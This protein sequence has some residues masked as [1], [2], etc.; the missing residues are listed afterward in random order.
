MS[1]PLP[2]R[3]RF[4]SCANFSCLYLWTPQK[5]DMIARDCL[6]LQFGGRPAACVK[7]NSERAEPPKH[8]DQRRHPAFSVSTRAHRPPGRGRAPACASSPLSHGHAALS[9]PQRKTLHFCNQS[10]PFFCADDLWTSI[11]GVDHRYG[12]FQGCSGRPRICG[13][14]RPRS[15]LR[16]APEDICSTAAVLPVRDALSSDARHHWN[17]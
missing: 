5:G 17:G 14:R 10:T 9:P 16:L 6:P 7:V 4:L 2:K 13:R 11:R 1:G 15:C 8:I 12:G 3:E